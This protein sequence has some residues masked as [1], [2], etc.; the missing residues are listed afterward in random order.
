MF[1]FRP[2]ASEAA[3]SVTANAGNSEAQPQQIDYR[4]VERRTPAAL[5]AIQSGG[6]LL[7]QV[8]NSQ[9]PCIHIM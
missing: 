3:E 2:R 5:L 7:G 1:R 4:L 6:D 8:A 9:M